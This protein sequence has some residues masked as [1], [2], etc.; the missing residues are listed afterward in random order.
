[1][2]YAQPTEAQERQFAAWV[3][4][5]P[6]VI[7]ALI[8][9]RRFDPWTLYRLKTTGQRVYIIS[10]SEP[11]E[12]GGKVTLRVVVSGKF[13]LVAFE[14]GVFGIDPD[15]LEECDLPDPTPQELRCGHGPKHGCGKSKKR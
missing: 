6:D 3:A 5:R 4:E 9:A 14:R 11:E 13:N 12:S 7:R 2:R 1:M 10:F 15:D 8:S